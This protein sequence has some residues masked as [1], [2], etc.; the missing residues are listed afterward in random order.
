MKLFKQIFISL[1]LTVF[2]TTPAVVFGKAAHP[3]QCSGTITLPS[4][5]QAH[6]AL[7]INLADFKTECETSGK[8]QSTYV[9]EYNTYYTTAVDET[10]CTNL[11][12]TDF[13]KAIDML[14]YKSSSTYAIACKWDPA[15]PSTVASTTATTPSREAIIPVLSVNIPGLTFST[16]TEDSTDKEWE[17]WDEKWK[18][19]NL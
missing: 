3:C 17:E 18:Q 6:A 8:L 7:G 16:P 19:R 5:S 11:S 14:K 2:L 4:Q 15:I 1:V 10:A 13:L 12:G 9:C